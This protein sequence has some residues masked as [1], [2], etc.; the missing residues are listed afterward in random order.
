MIFIVNDVQCV[1]PINHLRF[2]NHLWTHTFR[3]FLQFYNWEFW[4]GLE[5]SRHLSRHLSYEPE[6]RS[7]AE[8][9]RSDLRRLR[10]L[11]L[12]LLPLL[13]LVLARLERGARVKGRRGGGVVVDA[14]LDRL[15]LDA[16]A[17]ADAVQAA[18]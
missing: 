3:K 13:P 12:R 4:Q 15:H 10:D 9:A 17:D 6:R 14:E 5:F 18:H 1:S 11:R 2:S 8:T 7:A 16:T